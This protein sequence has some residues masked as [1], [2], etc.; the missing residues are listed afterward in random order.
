M[1]HDPESSGS[2]H[3]QGTALGATPITTNPQPG[4]VT[5]NDAREL[6]FTGEV[7]FDT[8]PE[9]RT[10]F[11]NGVVYFAERADARPI[12]QRLLD[13]GLLDRTQLD[14]G[15]VRV[16]D[17]E[18]LGRLFDR[19]P[20]VDRDA[21]L[22]LTES[23]TEQ[24]VTELANETITT[25]RSTAYR[26]HP[27]G[28]HRWFVDRIEAESARASHGRGPFDTGTIERVSALPMISDRALADQLY[29]EWDEPILG[30]GKIADDS[31]LLDEFDDSQLQAMLDEAEYADVLTDEPLTA[32][33][34][35]APVAVNVDPGVGDAVD[36]FQVR[37]PNDASNAGSADPAER[38]SD[39]ERL[40]GASTGDI[41]V[42][43]I[44]PDAAPDSE[45]VAEV[46]EDVAESVRR[47]I[48]ALESA[49]ARPPTIASI[50]QPAAFFDTVVD[51]TTRAAPPARAPQVATEQTPTSATVTSQVAPPSF[52]GFAPPSLDQSVEA[53]YARAIAAS[54]AEAVASIDEGAAASSVDQYVVSDPVP[55]TQPVVGADGGGGG[56][57]GDFGPGDEPGDRSSALKR[58][59]G[60][61]RRPRPS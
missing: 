40:D 4:W 7:V 39:V 27:S 45:L 8:E 44:E 60:S 47:A 53:I 19:D 3:S 29:I 48:A 51:D 16:G 56:G 2:R 15:I 42:R 18:H 6:A 57:G 58:L 28:I 17:V 41:S 1:T 32:A 34:T 13:L 31:L 33:P 36:Q 26:H 49:S 43:A 35:A 10:Y 59:I 14:R 9:V 52:A 21:I 50:A 20:S 46:P 5:L 22:V 25:V 61:L 24:L 30:H 38:P 23:E 12:G 37:T 55:A 54:E 11:D